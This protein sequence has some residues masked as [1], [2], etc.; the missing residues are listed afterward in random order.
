LKVRI[1][2]IVVHPPVTTTKYKTNKDEIS[3]SVV[4]GKVHRG[5]RR[6]PGATTMCEP[7]TIKHPRLALLN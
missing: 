4:K 5:A 7:D 6:G 2:I 1:V 3:K